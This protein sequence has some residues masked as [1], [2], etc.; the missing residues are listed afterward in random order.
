MTGGDIVVAHGIFV[1]CLLGDGYAE[2][3][4]RKETA[5]FG[6]WLVGIFGR[7]WGVILVQVC[8]KDDMWVECVSVAWLYIL[9][10]CCRACDIVIVIAVC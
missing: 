8:R 3:R 5:E 2:T 10:A 4:K 9:G 1:I 6:S 7:F